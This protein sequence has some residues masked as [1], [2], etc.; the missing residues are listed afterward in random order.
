MQLANTTEKKKVYFEQ[1]A[2]L[3]LKRQYP[4]QLN[5]LQHIGYS[6]S[7]DLQDS[8][9]SMG[10]EVVTAIR[11]QECSFFFDKYYGKKVPNDSKVLSIMAG[12]N[13]TFHFDENNQVNCM[14]SDTMIDLSPTQASEIAGNLI[15]IAG[16]K[17]ID[18]LN[19]GHFYR[20]NTNGL[21]IFADSRVLSTTIYRNMGVLAEYQKEKPQIFD[22]FF[23]LCKYTLFVFNKDGTC[24]ICLDA[25]FSLIIIVE[26]LF[27][28]G[29][30][31]MNWAIV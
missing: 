4:E 26:P 16:Q 11:N 5:G 27:A 25:Y 14:Y 21:F 30:P 20:F 3:I 9:A 28:L 2:R 7:P 19:N 8:T 1:L 13:C 29:V 31:V 15:I 24:S 23:I 12:K 10:V 17:K 22:F 18:K 6:K